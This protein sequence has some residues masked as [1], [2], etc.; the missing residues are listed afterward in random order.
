MDT[1]PAGPRAARIA[2]F[3][4]AAGWGDA[5]RRALG[6]DW[7]TRRYERLTRADGATALLMDAAGE[8]AAQVAPFIRLGRRLAG[9]DLRT[10]AILAAAADDGLALIEDFGDTPYNALLEDGAT[11]WRPLYERATDVLIAMHRRFRVAE[12]DADLPRYDAALFGAQVALFADA[13]L[14][15]VWGRALTAAETAAVAAAWDGVLR[16][17]LSDPALPP[18]SLLLRDYHPGNLMHLRTGEGIAACGLLDFQDGGIGPRAYDLVSLLQDARRDV[19]PD[20][21]AAMV[22]RYEAAFP[23]LDRAAFARCFAVM[24]AVRHARILG[25]VAQLLA[26]NPAAPQALLLP[27]VSAQLRA[28]LSHPALTPIRLL[29]PPAVAA[30][31]P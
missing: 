26:L 14:P 1:L 15:R 28:A 17:T 31:P 21:A 16:A 25:R 10:P 19:P 5:A 2:D 29:L 6:A 13:Y 11:A 9:L 23:D 27:R 8:A 4:T 24:A 12:G 22:A 3:L 7:S 20:L 18:D 30:S